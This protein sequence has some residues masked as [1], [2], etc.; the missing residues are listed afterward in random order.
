MCRIGSLKHA[1]SLKTVN[2]NPSSDTRV[3]YLLCGSLGWS[4]AP[5]SGDGVDVVSKVG[6]DTEGV[7]SE[8]GKK[9]EG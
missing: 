1:A 4:S 8:N 2:S 3:T 7:Y 5:M 9:K 6:G